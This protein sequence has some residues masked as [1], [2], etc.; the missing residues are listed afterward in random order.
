MGRIAS[1]PWLLSPLLLLLLLLVALRS[2]LPPAAVPVPV[3]PSRCPS[4]SSIAA[5][6]TRCHDGSSGSSGFLAATLYAASS[7]LASLP[8][9]P[10]GV[11]AAATGEHSSAPACL[12]PGWMD[13]RGGAE[14]AL[15]MHRLHN[16][17]TQTMLACSY[18]CTALHCTALCVGIAVCPAAGDGLDPQ[19]FPPVLFLHEGVAAT[20]TIHLRFEAAPGSAVVAA[21]SIEGDPSTQGTVT[22]PTVALDPLGT[23]PLVTP[24]SYTPP[25]STA[26]LTAAI[27]VVACTS[28]PTK[29]YPINYVA[30]ANQAHISGAHVGGGGVSTLP[31]YRNGPMHQA[32]FNHPGKGVLDISGDRLFIPDAGNHA[33]RVWM[34]GGLNMDD[35]STFWGPPPPTD[36]RAVEPFPN[37]GETISGSALYDPS[38]RTFNTPTAL[39][40]RSDGLRLFISD[41]MNSRVM[42]MT[43]SDASEAESLEPISGGTGYSTPLQDG[44]EGTLGASFLPHPGALAVDDLR[45]RLYVVVNAMPGYFVYNGQIPTLAEVDLRAGQ[46]FRVRFLTA[47]VTSSSFGGALSPFHYDSFG[48]LGAAQDPGC[49]GAVAFIEMSADASALYIMSAATVSAHEVGAPTAPRPSVLR[50]L[51]LDR[52]PAALTTLLSYFYSPQESLMG[53][54]RDGTPGVG[55]EHTQGLVGSPTAMALHPDGHTLY[56][57]DSGLNSFSAVNPEEQPRPVYCN[58]LNHTGVDCDA[59]IRSIDLRTGEVRTL[60]GGRATSAD[61]VGADA[62][63]W[64]G[65]TIMQHNV[66]GVPMWTTN[67]LLM[68]EHTQQ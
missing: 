59:S 7:A 60:A 27:L 63:L 42:M 32:L 1:A 37:G 35:V 11:D 24:L 28:Y 36:G 65:H 66:E 40:L 29:R 31:G 62:G 46:G 20:Q 56:F 18:R 54:V 68:S 25:A 13:G 45:E 57:I 41:T 43:L 3:P 21:I 9:L 58:S 10:L 4:T 15:D 38:A 67:T 50:V 49:L 64:S 61:G 19:L 48:A 53:V 44:A 51:Q 2:A 47:R 14:R 23:Y 55:V 5:A 30:T 26:G 12:L 22:P 17:L 52:E 33:I 6:H 39:A 34:M 16:R 8:F